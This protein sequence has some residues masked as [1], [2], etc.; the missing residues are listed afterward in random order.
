M[1]AMEY[2]STNFILFNIAVGFFTAL[3][4]VSLFLFFYV[5]GS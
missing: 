5:L 2:K 1:K 4:L 3:L